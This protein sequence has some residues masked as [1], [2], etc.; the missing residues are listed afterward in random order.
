MFMT[1][2]NELGSC[3]HTL[4]NYL[5]SLIW[6]DKCDGFPLYMSTNERVP[7]GSFVHRLTPPDKKIG[8]VAVT[9]AT[10]TAMP[11]PVS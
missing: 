11:L 7:P 4:L 6:L 10:S 2:R 5:S 9:E 3:I 1:C 8:A